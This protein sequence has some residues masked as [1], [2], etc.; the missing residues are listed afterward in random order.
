MRKII[1]NKVYDTDTATRCGAWSNSSDCREASYIQ[2][3]LYKKR[4]NEF[5]L[6]CE[7]GA[8]SI[9]CAHLDG[10]HTGY[11]ERI[12]PLS[13]GAAREWAE[14]HLS[15]EDYE[16]TFGEVSEENGENVSITFRIPDVLIARLSKEAAA[17][18]MSLSAYVRKKLEA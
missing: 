7:G 14:E 15:A 11:G 18:E 17:S 12:N 13:Y 6:H 10:N 2:E 16:E 5:F 9:Y 1:N 8:A 4:T 3:S